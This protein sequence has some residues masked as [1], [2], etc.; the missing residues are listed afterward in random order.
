[1]VFVA[2]DG[3]FREQLDDCV[4]RYASHANSGANTQAF[5]K[6]LNNL[7]AALFC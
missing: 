4:L 6:A 2:G 5:A 3:Y 7:D 1:L